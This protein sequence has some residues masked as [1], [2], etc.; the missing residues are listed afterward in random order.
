MGLLERLNDSSS[1]DE[2]SNAAASRLDCRASPVAI[3]GR[4][5]VYWGVGSHLH[6]DIM[7]LMGD[8]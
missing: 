5:V 4:F 3:C 8:E 2:H 1:C 6:N 7:R